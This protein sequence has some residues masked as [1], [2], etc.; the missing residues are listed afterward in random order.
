MQRI[1]IYFT[2]EVQHCYHSLYCF[3][4]KSFLVPLKHFQILKFCKR[5]AAKTAPGKKKQQPR[6]V[7]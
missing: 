1:S 7:L 5:H 6:S 2:E 4:K 3:L